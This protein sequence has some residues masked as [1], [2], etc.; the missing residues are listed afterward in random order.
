MMKGRPILISVLA[1]GL[2]LALA[3]GLSL[4]QGSGPQGDG[5]IQAAPVGTSFT[6]QGRLNDGGSPANGSYDFE[7][8]LYSAASSGSQVGSTVTRDDRAVTDG[9]FT[10]ELDFGSGVFTGDA[11]WLEIGVRAGTSTGAYT[12]LTPRQALTAT[13]YAL[14]A[15]DA[16]LLDGQQASAFASAT[17][18]HMGGTWTGN[19]PLTISGSFADAPLVLNNG[20]GGAASG[21][22]LNPG[23]GL[24]IQSATDDGVQIDSAGQDGVIVLKNGRD[25]FSAVKAGGDGLYVKEAGDDG[26]DVRE[27]GDDGVYVEKAGTPSATSTSSA[28]NGFEVAGASGNG[29]YVGHADGI[30]VAVESAGGDGVYVGTTGYEGNGLYVSSAAGNGVVVASAHVDGVLVLRADN[31]GVDVSRADEHGVNVGIPEWDGLHVYSAGQDG[32]HVESA[33]QKGVHVGDAGEDGVYVRQAGTATPV[34]S[35]WSNG[36]EVA[37]AEGAGLFVG[38]A[39]EDGVHVQSAGGNG[40]FVGPA[41]DWAGMFMGRVYVGGALTKVGGGFKIDHPLAPEN[42]YLNHSFVESPDMMNVYNGNVTL[43]ANGEAWVELPAWFEALNQ[44]F[45]YQLTPIGAPGPNLYIAEEVKDNSFK[46]AGGTPGMRVS[47]QVTGI[48]H[49]P[50]AETN[51][52][53]VEEDKPP[54]EQGTY[55]QPEAYGMPETRGLA[56]R[57]AQAEGYE[58]SPPGR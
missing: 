6:Y 19:T 2:M 25:A 50:W 20:G 17:H 3:A 52:I 47:W 51:R 24:L 42:K 12:T 14:Y 22:T 4:A 48:R 10:V 29:L 43:D 5:G 1:L 37:G 35:S 44:D 32:V 40:V 57:E 53:P 27:A 15:L 54:D 26:V 13:P 21:L 31:D 39:G 11:R 49:D 55:L 8:K 46:I 7:F 38:S 16:D 18:N 28:R 36:F 45:R 30:G 56:Y 34:G 58:L 9:L 41:V 33:D 23:D